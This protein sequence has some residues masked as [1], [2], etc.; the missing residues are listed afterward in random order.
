LASP[1]G[2]VRRRR[3]QAGLG[4]AEQLRAG[5]RSFFRYARRTARLGGP[6][7]RFRLRCERPDR[8]VHPQSGCPPVCRSQRRGKGRASVGRW[9]RGAHC[10]TTGR[11]F[12]PQLRWS[13]PGPGHDSGACGDDSGVMARINQDLG[14]F[15]GAPWC[16]RSLSES[17]VGSALPSRDDGFRVPSSAVCANR[18][19]DFGAPARL[20]GTWRIAQAAPCSPNRA[21]AGPAACTSGERRAIGV[22]PSPGGARTV[23]VA[24]RS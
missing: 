16:I 5:K 23:S 9:H 21:A 24:L 10:P 1:S 19:T 11:S 15:V 13:P 14:L 20:T 18:G 22:V 17:P 8:P 6:G 12:G 2:Y 4:A 3:S 7:G